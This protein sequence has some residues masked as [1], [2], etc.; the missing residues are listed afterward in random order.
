MSSSAFYK[1]EQQK[2]FLEAEKISLFTKHGPTIGSY[3]EEILRDYIKKITPSSLKVTSGFVSS[4]ENYKDLKELQSRQIDILMYNSDLY[5][6]LLEA[7]GISVIRPE[8]LLGC[9]EIKSNLT[10]YKKK[11]PNNSKNVSEEYP[12]GGMHQSSYRWAG[13][14][15][16][17]LINIK[18]CA[19]ACQ[20]RKEAYFSGILSFSSNFELRKFYEA[21][22]NGEIQRQIGINHL[23]QL[24]IAICVMSKSIVMFF[25]S[26]IF[27]SDEFCNEYKS[28]FN[29]F[30]A[31][32]GHEEY[33]FQ[34]FTVQAYNQ[35]GY[36]HS[37]RE[38][39]TNGLFS[40]IGAKTGIWSNPFDL[41]CD[42]M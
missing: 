38:A 16:D 5:V 4:N 7:G 12:L 22:D 13:S 3:R 25:D 20:S 41:P 30:S 1:I 42:G 6:P 9:I 17:S 37:K 34:L 21:L 40:A 11:N 32:E 27:S 29:E 23:R 26:N 24:P 14:L 8:S 28:Y 15:V 36:T 39:D 31:I 2:L 10:F 33:P 18:D 35:I 19:D